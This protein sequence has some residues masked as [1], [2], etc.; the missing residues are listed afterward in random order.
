MTRPTRVSKIFTKLP[1][2][3]MTSKAIHVQF[4]IRKLVFTIIPIAREGSIIVHISL[5]QLNCKVKVIS[6]HKHTLQNIIKYFT[7][8]NSGYFSVFF[9]GSWTSAL[10]AVTNRMLLP[11]SFHYSLSP[12]LYFSFSLS[13]SLSFSLSLSLK[14]YLLS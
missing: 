13:L 12:S 14:T 10:I 3:N 8:S 11:H 9:T 1:V 2:V 4:P 7:G 5:K 6:V